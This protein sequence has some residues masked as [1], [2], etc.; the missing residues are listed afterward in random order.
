MTMSRSVSDFE[1]WTVNKERAL[2]V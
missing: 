1:I 2:W